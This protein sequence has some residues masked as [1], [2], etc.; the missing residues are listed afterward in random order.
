MDRLK[1]SAFYAVR[2]YDWTTVV[3]SWKEAKALCHGLKGSNN[4]GANSRAEAEWLLSPECT[5]PWAR[6][7]VYAPPPA[8]PSPTESPPTGR[9][10]EWGEM[11]GENG[12]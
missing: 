4:K 2:I 6:C 3:G 9:L 5:D 12:G 7:W 1:E 8:V 10:V 11:E